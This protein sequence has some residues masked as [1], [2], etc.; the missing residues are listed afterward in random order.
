MMNK[1]IFLKILAIL[2]SS[3]I[4]YSS[5]ASCQQIHQNQQEVAKME[6]HRD[7]IPVSQ[8]TLSLPLVAPDLFSLDYIMGHF[9]PATHPD[10]VA[11]DSVYA[12]RQ[13][14]YLR[15]ETYEAFRLM[16]D[17]AYADGIC[18]QIV[19][20]TRNFDSQKAIWE[21]KWTGRVL[22]E[23]DENLAETTPDPSAMPGTSRHHWG[24]DIDLNSV[25]NSYFEEDEGIDVYK[26]LKKHAAE[27]GFF[28][29]YVAGR[30]YGFLEEQWHWSYKPV[31]T[32]L[33]EFAKKKLTNEMIT[34]FMGSE[35]A[36]LIDVV[37]YYMWGLMK[38]ASKSINEAGEFRNSDFY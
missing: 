38:I 31:S 25:E 23:N 29:P 7:T 32:L 35:S 30:P 6:I 20:A 28:Q 5:R 10:F 2:L 3:T 16:Y 27:H 36:V 11:V 13:G 14:L 33:T 22:I 17:H 15:K 18:L 37:K 19:S 26:W 9:D 8:D 12:V 34:G 21:A 24:T 4:S 1:I